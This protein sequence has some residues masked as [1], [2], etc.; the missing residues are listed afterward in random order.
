MKL[1]LESPHAMNVVRFAPLLFIVFFLQR[2]H[3]L[4]ALSRRKD[5]AQLCVRILRLDVSQALHSC[6][7]A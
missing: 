3:P 4:L 7:G 1:T 5:R 2:F 6:D